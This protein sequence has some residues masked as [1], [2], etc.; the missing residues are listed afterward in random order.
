MESN[1]DL[2]HKPVKECSNLVNQ[3]RKLQF[4]EMD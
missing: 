1:E 2:V 4:L 3:R